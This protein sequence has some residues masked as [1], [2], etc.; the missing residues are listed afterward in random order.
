MRSNKNR[1]II[2]NLHKQVWMVSPGGF[3]FIWSR[4]FLIILFFIRNR[5]KNKQQ[6]AKKKKKGKKKN[7][8]NPSLID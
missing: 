1:I 3:L 2:F 5:Y 6:I 7:P 4:L 8:Q